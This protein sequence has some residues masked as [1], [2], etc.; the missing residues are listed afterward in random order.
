MSGRRTKDQEDRVQM[1][2][3]DDD[4]NVLH[5]LPKQKKVK[6]KQKHSLKHSVET[7]NPSAKKH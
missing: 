1:V 6:Q 4:E 3:R 7:N 2:V 5:S